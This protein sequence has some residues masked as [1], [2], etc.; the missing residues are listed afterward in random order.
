MRQA[1]SE[2]AIRQHYR[3]ERDRQ[4]DVIVTRMDTEA[5]KQ[6]EDFDAKMEYDT[7]DYDKHFQST[8]I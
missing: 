5:L 8:P 6:Q 1:E 4:I 2:N 3:T 7:S